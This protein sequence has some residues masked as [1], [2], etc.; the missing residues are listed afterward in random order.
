MSK[1]H[2]CSVPGDQFFTVG[3]LSDKVINVPLTDFF[4]EHPVFL[5]LAQK[6]GNSCP[7]NTDKYKCTVS[8]LYSGLQYFPTKMIDHFG[9]F[10]PKGFWRSRK[11][12][13]LAGD[14]FGGFEVLV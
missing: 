6:R 7:E 3:S 2:S 10:K 14:H 13:I 4:A 9:G 1:P 5:M 11:C 12:I 8:K